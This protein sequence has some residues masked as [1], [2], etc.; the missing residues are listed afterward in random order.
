MTPEEVYKE[1]EHDRPQLESWWLRQRKIIAKRALKLNKFPVSEWYEY[2]THRRNRY[3]VL[4]ILFG[5]KYSWNVITSVFALH[6]REDG[7]AIYMTRFSWQYNASKVVFLPH[8]LHRYAERMNIQKTGID[9][10]KHFMKQQSDSVI[11]S[12]QKLSGLSVRYKGQELLCRCFTDGIELGEMRDD[13]FVAKTFITYDMAK[14]LQKEAFEEGRKQLRNYGQLM[15][16]LK[17]SYL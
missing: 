1:I 13:I 4:S 10:V 2:Q 15:E 5:R 9:L 6:N 16:G 3:F 7:Y 8:V 17:L 14:G 12:D 11:F